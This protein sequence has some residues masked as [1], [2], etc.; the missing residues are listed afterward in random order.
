MSLES[1]NQQDNYYHPLSVA[2]SLN[3]KKNSGH[4]FCVLVVCPKLLLIYTYVCNVCI[5]T[6]PKELPGGGS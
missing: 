4:T 1:A 2:A 6:H 5:D 3:A